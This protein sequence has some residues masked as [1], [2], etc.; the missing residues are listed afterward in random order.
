MFSAGTQSRVIDAGYQNC[1]NSSRLFR[2]GRNGLSRLE[3]TRSIIRVPIWLCPVELGTAAA[4]CSTIADGTAKAPA[5]LGLLRVPDKG[6]CCGLPPPLSLTASAPLKVPRDDELKVTVMVHDPFAITLLP[7]VFV[8]EK[9]VEPVMLMPRLRLAVR[10][11]VN[12]TA[13]E[14]GGHELEQVKD[15][16]LGASSTTVPAPFRVT[17]CEPPGA[18][19]VIDRIAV[20]VPIREGVKVTSIAQ[21]VPGAT[22]RPQLL[23]WAKSLGFA[24]VIVIPAIVSGVAP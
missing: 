8:W 16:L 23:V 6:T 1:H 12:V 22:S 19:S 5:P 24:P 2:S 15:R 20:R 10:V 14:G 21:L 7:Q 3:S 18:L 11:F 17:F 13:C 4:L 9:V